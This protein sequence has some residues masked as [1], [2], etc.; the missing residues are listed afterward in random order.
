M[1]GRL[2][3]MRLAHSFYLFVEFREFREDFV[4]LLGET[5]PLNLRKSHCRFS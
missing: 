3:M 1:F 5:K 2:R 4:E